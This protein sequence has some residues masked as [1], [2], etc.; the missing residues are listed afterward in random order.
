MFSEVLRCGRFDVGGYL[1]VAELLE[2]VAPA[3]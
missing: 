3:A 1:K 2:Q